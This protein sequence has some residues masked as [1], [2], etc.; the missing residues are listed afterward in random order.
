MKYLLA[1]HIPI[2]G[3]SLIPLVFKWPL[4]LMPV[5]IAFLHLIIDPVCSVV[6]E[7]EPEESDVM[8]R[9]PRKITERLFSR[10]MLWGSL[11]QGTS[12]LI[13]TITV[14]AIALFRGQSDVDARALTFV[15]LMVAN[16]SL[17]LASRSKA[18]K[19]LNFANP[20]LWWVVLGTF[21]AMVLIFYYPFTRQLFR[22]SQLHPMDWLICFI[23]GIT[24]V[25]WLEGWKN[26]LSLGR[27]SRLE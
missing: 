17:I 20:A 16:L 26:A 27:K 2:A 13:S 15:T 7:M 11:L 10:E 4:I 25:Y 18:V 19:F 1:I 8:H 21:A 9:P 3:M 14:F 12:I 6:F 24:S 23:A 5:H 22:F